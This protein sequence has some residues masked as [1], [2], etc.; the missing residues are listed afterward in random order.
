MFY[1]GIVMEIPDAEKDVEALSEHLQATTL[2]DEG[3]IA[4]L[5]Q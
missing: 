3:N 1:V 2:S 4:C 5:T